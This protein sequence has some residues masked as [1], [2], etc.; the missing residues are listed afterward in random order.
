MV[1]LLAAAA[2]AWPLTLGGVVWHRAVFGDTVPTLLIHAAAAHICHQR[3]ERSFHTAG[4]QWPVCGRCSGLYLGAPIGAA[5]AAA[6]LAG[7]RRAITVP[8]VAAIAAIPTA[9]T[10][11]LEWTG[12]V[13]V[14]NQ[15]RFLAA[16]P[17]GAAVALAMMT[18][19]APGATGTQSHDSIHCTPMAQ[20][21]RSAARAEAADRTTVTAG[22]APAVVAL[23]ALLVP[24]L[25]HM[26]LGRPRKAAVFCLMLLAMFAIG[27][28]FGGRLFPFQL[29]EPLVFLMAV[30][31]WA[32][33]L[34]R[35][36]AG[37]AGWGRG[38]VISITY[39]YGNTFLI[40][41]GLLNV[42]IALDAAD[43]AAGRKPR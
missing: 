39:E 22:P 9:L 25:G 43:R 13:T 24:G 7:R 11:V 40:V 6:W 20:R 12:V 38:D 31:E 33:A 27:L 19:A 28:A 17:L 1:K 3:P 35:L 23:L 30:A 42:L 4:V 34:P 8:G 16:L 32:V 36:F 41:A 26:M 2:V 21:P 37:L 10:M 5:V 29:A 18:A 14:S 15:A